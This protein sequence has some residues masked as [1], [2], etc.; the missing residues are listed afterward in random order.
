MRVFIPLILFGLS[1][2]CFS[3]IELIKNGDFSD[4]TSNVWLFGENGASATASID[5]QKYQIIIN[6]PGN[7]LWSPQLQQ[8]DISLLKDT[9]Y[10][11]KFDTWATSSGKI[12]VIFCSSDYKKYLD[13]LVDISSIKTSF[14]INWIMNDPSDKRARIQFNFGHTPS[15]GVIGL[16]N[17]SLVQRNEPVIRVLKPDAASRLHSGTS[18]TIKWT[19]SGL[20]ERVNIR[21]S[22]DG[23]ES[24]IGVADSVENK[25][26]CSF[27]W[28]IPQNVYGNNC[29]VLISS[30]DGL[31]SDTSES[32]SVLHDAVGSSVNNLIQNSSF[33]NKSRWS[34]QVNSPATARDTIINEEMLVVIN[35]IGNASWQVKLKQEKIALEKGKLYEFSFDAYSSDTRTIYANIGF[36]NG[37]PVWSVNKGDSTPTTITSEKKRYKTTFFMNYPSSKSALVEFN[38]GNNLRDV[39]FDNILLHQINVPQSEF[40]EPLSG[41]VLKCND[42]SSI[43]WTPGPLSDVG[44]QFSSDSGKTWSVIVSEIVSNT[45]AVSWKVPDVSS[46]TCLLKIVNP[47]DG[48]TIGGSGVFTINKF[49]AEIKSGELVTNGSFDDSL[50][51]W[52]IVTL[53]SGVAAVPELDA[54]AF[55]MIITSGGSE[56]SDILLSQGGLI[57]L[58]GNTYLMSFKAFSVSQR[59]MRVRLVDSYTSAADSLFLDTLVNL[60]LTVED[61]RFEIRVPGDCNARIEYFLGGDTADVYIDNVSLR[62]L[63]VVKSIRPLGN[64][65]HAAFTARTLS[66]SKIEF[67]S[68]LSN[69][70]IIDIFTLQGVRVTTLSIV[71]GYALLD[72]LDRSAGIARGTYLARIKAGGVRST[73]L[74]SSSK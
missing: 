45:G 54:K 32:F 12:E 53:A 47:I 51:G 52:D 20:L 55:G 14:V 70:G 27:I 66:D 18:D 6:S 1:T 41:Q 69:S 30:P 50:N 15:P 13:T 58:S 63:P 49:G 24:W 65:Q 42:S 3:Q 19:Y 10:T 68:P 9:A 71:N 64:F 28:G 2:L 21:Y 17:V 16:D 22:V 31:Y 74:F 67:R 39:Y 56:R 48:E 72:K 43:K 35:S 59:L 11:L 25:A 37:M 60:S 29:L 26:P 40:L 33:H 62:I 23:G 44:L 46:S 4:S 34:L 38:L 73:I 8:L 57:L 5:H 36:S 61:F 7:S